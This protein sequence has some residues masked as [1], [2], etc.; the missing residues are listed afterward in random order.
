[1]FEWFDC[2]Y[3]S[4]DKFQMNSGFQ[5]KNS[6]MYIVKGKISYCMDKKSE[7]SGKDEL[8]C[9]PDD[10][11]FEREILE[12]VSF[13]YI[14][15]ENPE[16]CILPVGKVS[17]KDRSRLLS[18]LNYMHKL[19]MMP[20]DNSELKNYYLN[21]IFVQI[22]ADELMTNGN[23]DD[24]VKKASEFF[25]DNLDKKISLEDTAASVGVSVSGLI[26]HFKNQTGMTPVKYLCTMR[27]KKSE[28]L[29]CHTNSPISQ[30]AAECGFDNAYYFCNTF[31]KYNGIAPTKYRSK[32]G[33]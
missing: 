18:T 13:Y 12:P 10:I 20:E 17:V 30:I 1:M 29:L 32:Y 4:M 25:K 26:G 22:K 7:T 23:N 8:V 16:K 14:R 21:D 27:I 6:L 28:T 19:Q 11:Y 24:V 31:K 9:F 5:P 2:R 3:L 33:V 15:F